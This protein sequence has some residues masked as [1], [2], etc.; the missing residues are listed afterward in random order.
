M[1]WPSTLLDP[2][3]LITPWSNESCGN[4][5]ATQTAATNMASG[6]LTQN[7]AYFYPFTL[8]KGRT[9]VKM[10]ALTGATQNGNIDLGIYDDQFNC[11]V[12]LGATAMGAVNTLQEGNIADTH[13]PAGRYW[14]A[15]SCSSATGTC[16]Q[17]APADEFALSN[18]VVLMQASAHPLPTTSA[19][20]IRST[21]GGPKM[22]AIGVSFDT[23][24]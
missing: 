1:E 11:I 19:T 9:A 17:F 21:E 12:T 22:L 6:T 18:W 13:L 10:F 15:Y 4:A 5:L 14:M 16:F 8:T 20:P 2:P 23:L 3:P 7:Q 24:I